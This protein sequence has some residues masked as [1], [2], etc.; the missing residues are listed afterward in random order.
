MQEQDGYDA[1]EWA[2]KLPGSN[3]RVGV[4]GGSN[5]GLN[6][7]YAAIAAPPHLATIAG[8]FCMTEPIRRSC[9]CRLFLGEQ[10]TNCQ[11]AHAR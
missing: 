4:I 11:A 7:W 9:G 6:A 10:S 8:G 2:A 5:P 1:V 3:G